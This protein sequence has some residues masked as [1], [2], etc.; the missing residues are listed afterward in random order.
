MRLQTRPKTSGGFFIGFPSR[1]SQKGPGEFEY[2]PYF[3]FDK[4]EHDG[5]QKMGLKAI[6]EWVKENADG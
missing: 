5:F 1:R 4:E 2:H 3:K 6:D